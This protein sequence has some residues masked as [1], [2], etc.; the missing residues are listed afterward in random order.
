MT[1]PRDYVKKEEIQV[2]LLELCEE[3][4]SRARKAGKMGSTVSLSLNGA[5]YVEKRGF[6]GK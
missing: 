1:L 3:V 6:I 5:S 4:C 2:V